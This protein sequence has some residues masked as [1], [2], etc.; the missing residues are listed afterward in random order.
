M[1][2]YTAHKVGCKGERSRHYRL[3]VSVF[4]RKPRFTFGGAY[5]FG[6]MC[7]VTFGLLSVSAETKTHAFGKNNNNN[8]GSSW[9]PVPAFPGPETVTSKKNMNDYIVPW[10]VV[11]VCR[12]LGV[13]GDGVDEG[14]PS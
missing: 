3:S 10:R 6:R 9:G 2:H 13:V 5:G 7:Y 12:Q 14:T 1:T 11:Y 8:V 4:G